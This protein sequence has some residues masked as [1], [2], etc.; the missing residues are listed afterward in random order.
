MNRR[1]F[2]WIACAIVLLALGLYAVPTPAASGAEAAREKGFLLKEEPKDAKEV[3]AIREKAKHGEAVVVVGR[4]G[5]RTNPWV[6]G[7]AAFSIVDSSLKSC[8]QIEGDACPTP[9]DYC[10]EADINKSMLFVAFVDDAG[11][12][13]KKDARQL[14]KVKE[15]Q[16]VVV[17]G[18][19]KRD[20]ANNVSLLASKL[21]VRNPKQAPK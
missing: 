21:Y 10:C 2:C 15:L 3:K 14:L 16:T 11:K 20:K 7:T 9:W 17:Q 4:I 13:V 18:K 12:I 8:D 5:G 1:T 19:V 6:K